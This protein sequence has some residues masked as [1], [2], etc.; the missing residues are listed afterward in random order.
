MSITTS[1]PGCPVCGSVVKN[2][3]AS[4]HVNSNKHQAAMARG[5]GLQMPRGR[6]PPMYQDPYRQFRGRGRPEPESESE[7]EA[8][9]QDEESG[10]DY[11]GEDMG[12]GYDS[13]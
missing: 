11:G 7:D 10:D 6:A 12:G 8:Y 9:L 1:M 5:Y 2:P 3:F 13:A 4:S